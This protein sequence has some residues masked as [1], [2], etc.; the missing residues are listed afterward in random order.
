MQGRTDRTDVDAPL[1]RPLFIRYRSS[2]RVAVVDALA[3]AGA[4]CCLVL[5]DIPAWAALPTGIAVLAHYYH[6]LRQYLTPARCI[7]KLDQHDH[8]QLLPD[9]CAAL[10]LTLLPGA[11]VLTRLVVLR[12]RDAG[13]RVRQFVLTTDNLDEQTLRRLRARLRWPLST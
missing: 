10:R 6:S 3:H 2:K 11:L 9:G 13:G 12:F 1:E 4:V 5:A 8:W 7:L